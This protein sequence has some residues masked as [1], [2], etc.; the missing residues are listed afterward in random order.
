MNDTNS[1]IHLWTTTRLIVD[2]FRDK[3]WTRL[4]DWQLLHWITIDQGWWPFYR[5]IWRLSMSEDKWGKPF[6][7]IPMNPHLVSDG[8]SKSFHIWFGG[9]SFDKVICV[10]WLCKMFMHFLFLVYFSAPGL[11]TMW[12]PNIIGN[13]SKSIKQDRKTIGTNRSKSTDYY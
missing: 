6:L 9:H 7:G 4:I 2:L 12:K 10:E 13:P 11:G 8:V 1:I 3:R 5:L